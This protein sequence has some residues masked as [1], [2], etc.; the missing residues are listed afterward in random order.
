MAY[1]SRSLRQVPLVSR[2]VAL[3]RGGSGTSAWSVAIVSPP[4]PL[5]LVTGGIERES[6]FDSCMHA[7]I[8]FCLTCLF[9]RRW[10]EVSRRRGD[11]LGPVLNLCWGPRVLDPKA[12]TPFSLQWKG[13]LLG[14]S[15]TY[16][17]SC[18]CVC[19]SVCVLIWTEND[20]TPHASHAWPRWSSDL[21]LH[22]EC[23]TFQNT[24]PQRNKF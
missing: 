6:D 10:N 9:Y 16:R 1:I 3:R 12:S 24:W 19:V 15:Q 13:Q 22:D 20:L 8:F 18:A 17:S 5:A 4:G 7:Q 23:E 14:H 21:T 2:S 11:W